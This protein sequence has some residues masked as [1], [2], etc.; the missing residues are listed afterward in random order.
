MA[1]A[2]FF[3]PINDQQRFSATVMSDYGKRQR[4]GDEETFPFEHPGH[5]EWEELTS[6]MIAR[7]FPQ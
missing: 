3:Y 4:R 1:Q 2:Y 6:K 5:G 7:H